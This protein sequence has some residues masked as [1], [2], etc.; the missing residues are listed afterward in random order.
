MRRA[1]L[2]GA[3]ALGVMLGAWG[4]PAAA[5]TA[6]PSAGAV[7]RIGFL[8]YTG[9]TRDGLSLA[10]GRR[11]EK[12]RN[13]FL[14]RLRERGWIAGQNLLIELRESDGQRDTVA[15]QAAELVRLGVKLIVA[16]NAP[17]YQPARQVT[18]TVPI[19][20]CFHGDPVGAGHA[21]SLSHPGG[22]MTGVAILVTERAVKAFDLIT[23]TLPRA[24]RIAVLWNP[25]MAA[26]GPA[27]EAVE[28]AARSRGIEVLPI[29][30]S[31]DD[32]LAP[33][34]AAMAEKRVDGLLVIA[35]PLYGLRDERLAE[36]ALQHRLP[37]ILL[38]S[39]SVVAGVLMA[40]GFDSAEQYRH[41]AEY[42]DKIL[43][44]ARPADLP[45]EQ[46]STYQLSVNLK[47]AAALG[48][49]LPPAIVARAD[50]VI[51]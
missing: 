30:A 40:Y 36:L 2:A 35:S 6:S 26:A 14:E 24:R 7:P 16:P 5:Q 42:V 11:L 25:T 22:N 31:A 38:E 37:A 23:G 51:E 33:A 13:A 34:F 15:G 41:C 19:V 49:A 32:D 48:I 39:S 10:T 50:E 4:S 18:S 47:T 45:I 29:P 3:L 28:A 8:A 44:G 46:A 9:P 43:R 17:V 12:N 27:V 1:L 21:A 20:F